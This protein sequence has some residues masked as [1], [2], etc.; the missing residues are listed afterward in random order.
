[1]EQDYFGDEAIEKKIILI[2]MGIML[3]RNRDV[4]PAEL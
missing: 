1:M 3:V 4:K 2:K